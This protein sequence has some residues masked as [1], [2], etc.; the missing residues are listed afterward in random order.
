MTP[1]TRTSQREYCK[2]G[3]KHMNV[4]MTSYNMCSKRST[5]E[6]M[7]GLLSGA[8]SQ[9]FSSSAHIELVKTDGKHLERSGRLPSCTK[10]MTV[11]S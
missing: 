2:S 9:Q 1:I 10:A 6:S 3:G 7:L 4:K 11:V 8:V 5:I